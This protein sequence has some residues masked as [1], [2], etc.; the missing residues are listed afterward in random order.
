GA[1]GQFSAILL[2][3]LNLKSSQTTD[4]PAAGHWSEKTAQEA[5]KF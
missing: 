4:Y 2:N 5:E 3:F 1:T